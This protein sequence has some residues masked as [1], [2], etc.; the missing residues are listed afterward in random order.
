MHKDSHMSKMGAL[1]DIF[2]FLGHPSRY[3]LELHVWRY[4]HQCTQSMLHMILIYIYIKCDNLQA[5]KY[6]FWKIDE[7][8]FKIILLLPK[9]GQNSS[10]MKILSN[11]K[12]A[13]TGKRAL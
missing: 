12:M 4:T 2:D 13:G 3:C 10:K 6:N 5:E 9:N 7:N 1:K 11:V 8:A